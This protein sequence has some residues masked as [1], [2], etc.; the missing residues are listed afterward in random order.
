MASEGVVR[1]VKRLGGTGHEILS[2]GGGELLTDLPSLQK[3][4][5]GKPN[6]C[7]FIKRG[8]A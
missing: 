8:K 2:R 1:E 6:L 4:G 3:L 5:T 7:F